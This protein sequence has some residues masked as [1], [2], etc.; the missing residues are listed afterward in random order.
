[1]DFLEDIKKVLGQ[2][3][4]PSAIQLHRAM[5]GLRFTVQDILPYITEPTSLSYGRNVIYHSKDIE[6]IVLHFPNH[7]IT[8]IHDHGDSIGCGIV[9]EGELTEFSYV[10]NKEGTP[11]LVSK[12]SAREKEFF[13]ISERHIH[14][15]ANEKDE[16]LITLHVY[17]PP[18][19]G[20]KYFKSIKECV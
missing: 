12:S 11:E 7:S 18:L 4:K 2:M 15:M 1:M 20:I 13:H 9:V 17:S 14:A 5:E 10:I 8:D 19:N 3:N 16:R 6:V